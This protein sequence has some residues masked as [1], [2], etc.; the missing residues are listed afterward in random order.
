MSIRLRFTLFYS[1]ILALTLCVFSTV[2]YG[3][4]A[5]YTLRAIEN[6]LALNASR[7]ALGLARFGLDEMTGL[8]YFWDRGPNTQPWRSS[9]IRLPG[10][11]D[12][13][14]ERLR[15]RNTL[16]LLDAS[17]VPVES[18]WNEA[19]TVMPISPQGLEQLE[20][21]QAWS[22]IVSGEQGRVLVHNEPVKVGDRVIGIV[23]VSALLADRDRSLRA[24]AMTLI[25]GSLLTTVVAFGIG[26]LL[27]GV[28]LRPI[29]RITQ[30]ARQI[31]EER[32]LARRVRY[33]GPNDELGQLA[34]TLNAMLARLQEA[35]Q[36][37][38]RALQVQRDFVADV[39]HELRTPLTTIR[40][41]LALLDHDPPVPR[42][43]RDD[44]LSDVVD[45]T[46][47]L[48]R[49]IHDL[50]TLARTDAGHKFKLDLVDVRDLIQETCRQAQQLAPER[51]IECTVIDRAVVLANRDALKQVILILLDNAL[52]HTTQPIR[53]SLDERDGHTVIKVRDRSSGMSPELCE[54]IF[55]RFYRGDESRST[56]GFGLGLS[57]AKALV[58]AQ[59]ADIQVSSL[60]GRGSTFTVTFPIAP[61]T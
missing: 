31:G 11:S 47:R 35:Y 13:E 20:T 53:V 45:E 19:S 38:E 55:D 23:Q 10:F 17:G 46:E 40:G 29:H 2:L 59:Q 26:W 8:P 25:S 61:S 1:I 4:Q 52:K 43:E 57:I 22:E 56:A 9:E 32:D 24:L 49:L 34:R 51:E 42:A 36:Q 54:R 37:V 14:I 60:P 12:R 28:T 41:N 21:G 27:A 30:T 3:I 15:A 39:S 16:Q 6:D 50:L 33:Q 7:L 18:L 48:I 58:Q 5:Q 44:I